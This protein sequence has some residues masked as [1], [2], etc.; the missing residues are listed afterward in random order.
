LR[1]SEEGRR[2]FQELILKTQSANL[3]FH[4]FHAGTIHRCQRL[5]RFRVLTAVRVHPIP[6]CSI[7]N[8]QFPGNLSYR[9]S[10][11]EHHLH[12]LSPKLRTEL[13]PMF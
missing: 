8:T 3:V 1:P 6:Q 4:F 5:I 7:M 9:L 2:F 11:G 10:R 12:S 13:A